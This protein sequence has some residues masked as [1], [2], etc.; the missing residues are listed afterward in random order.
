[1]A[2]SRK[3]TRTNKGRLHP[4]DKR[5]VKVRTSFNNE[6]QY[7]SSIES[8]VDALQAIPGMDDVLFLDASKLLE[9]EKKAQMFVAMDVEQRR[10]WL[11]RKL[12][13]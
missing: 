13:R 6:D 8:I 12:R 4:S 11:L 7:Y 5:P 2:A 1:M 9:D 3:A 10:K